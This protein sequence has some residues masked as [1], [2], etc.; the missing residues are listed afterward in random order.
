MSAQS[1]VGMSV[2][3]LI[4][5]YIRTRKGE[6]DRPETAPARGRAEAVGALHRECAERARKASEM[7]ILTRRMLHS[8]RAQ[9][10]WYDSQVDT[11]EFIA[12]LYKVRR[13]VRGKFVDITARVLFASKRYRLPST[14]ALDPGN[15]EY[16]RTGRLVVGDRRLVSYGATSVLSFQFSLKFAPD[17][18]HS[19]RGQDDWGA[20]LN[21]GISHGNRISAA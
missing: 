18:I 1:K 9:F 5:G 19:G 7:V 3:C 10:V 13:C 2:F 12:E 14:I 16:F 8:S 6:R 11:S 4:F 20:F 17:S 21:W 15:R